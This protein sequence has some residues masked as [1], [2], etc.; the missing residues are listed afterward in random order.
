MSSPTPPEP[1]H[2]SA[3]ARAGPRWCE[4]APSSSPP[5]PPVQADQLG[6]VIS[7]SA[8]VRA[9][10]SQTLKPAAR[11]CG[12]PGGGGGGARSGEPRKLVQRGAPP[13]P[14]PPA[15]PTPLLPLL[16]HQAGARAR[17]L[18]ELR[19]AALACASL[20]EL[21]DL[22]ARAH[23][24]DSAL[25][26]ALMQDEETR[27][28]VVLGVAA[29]RLLAACLPGAPAAGPPAGGGSGGG[30]GASGGGGPAESSRGGDPDAQADAGPA[31]GKPGASGAS[32]GGLS[33]ATSG[34]GGPATHGDAA[35][36]GTGGGPS[37]P[38]A[39]PAIISAG[40][41]I[42]PDPA[43]FLELL[44]G[45]VA[46]FDYAPAPDLLGPGASIMRLFQGQPA[47]LASRA[48]HLR[49][50]A[51]LAP[52]WA[53]GKTAQAMAIASME[54][55]WGDAVDG[56]NSG[57]AAVGVW[58]PAVNAL[59]GPSVQAELGKMVRS[60]TGTSATVAHKIN[61]LLASLVSEAVQ[62]AMGAAARALS[63][64]TAVR[65]LAG[66]VPAKRFEL[67]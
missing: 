8:K 28:S 2:L 19:K 20:A 18:V 62:E 48:D 46:Q 41:G 34:S 39:A 61:V 38:N 54:A 60:W 12:R 59:G 30:P 36:S 29:E 66:M 57:G 50:R 27:A 33:P 6:V 7:A 24:E 26:P 31:G 25:Q 42:A 45:W 53:A 9:K 4:A 23:G 11:V 49:L 16:P 47:V 35:A 43:L 32:G 52:S 56:V 3:H 67:P 10:A 15:P 51:R 63:Q 44:P 55:W 14:A 22:A 58:L 37:A 17:V 21:L 1:I 5:I 40:G 13:A 64:C 65:L